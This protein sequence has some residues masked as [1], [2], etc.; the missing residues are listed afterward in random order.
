MRRDK[1]NHHIVLERR[2]ETLLP[3]CPRILYTFYLLEREKPTEN[4]E[5]FVRNPCQIKQRNEGTQLQIKLL[6]YF[7]VFWPFLLK[8]FLG[9][10]KKVLNW[11]IKRLKTY[12]FGMAPSLFKFT[13]TFFKELL[14]CMKVKIK[15]R[16]DHFIYNRERER[17]S[18][19]DLHQVLSSIFWE[20]EDSLLLLCCPVSEAGPRITLSSYHSTAFLLPY[21]CHSSYIQVIQRDVAH[22]LSQ[23]H[24]V[25]VFWTMLMLL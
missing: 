2:L 18:P 24:S 16:K 23:C 4:L 15:V 13:F 8:V 19:P 3:D 17:D 20:S 12:M 21:Y 9:L 7:R 10:I 14:D 1:C 11:K 25:G 5:I 6:T 22:P